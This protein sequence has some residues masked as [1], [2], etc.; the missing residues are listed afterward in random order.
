LKII[1]N[2][3][4]GFLRQFTTNNNN[5]YKSISKG[6]AVAVTVPLTPYAAH[7]TNQQP[8]QQQ[9]QQQEPQ[10]QQQPHY[11]SSF[12]SNY[13]QSNERTNRMTRI[14]F[15]MSASPIGIYEPLMPSATAENDQISLIEPIPDAPMGERQSHSG[16]HGHGQTDS[17]HPLQLDEAEEELVLR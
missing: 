7:K 10:H 13:P 2:I 8:Q 11:S 3:F 4:I 9:Q 6:V 1:I 12:H 5:K 17:D 16:M 15:S 14:S